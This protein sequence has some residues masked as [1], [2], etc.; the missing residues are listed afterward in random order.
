[1]QNN[2]TPW[3]GFL[4]DPD[5]TARINLLP[6][7][8]VHYLPGG[9]VP[10]FEQDPAAGAGRKYEWNGGTRYV[11]EPDPEPAGRNTRTVLILAAVG[12]LLAFVLAGVLVQ[13]ANLL[14]ASVPLIGMDS[15]VAT[16]QAIAA[17][18][19][20]VAGSPGGQPMTE[21]SYRELRA[22][23][24]DSRYPA[25]RDN[26]VQIVDISWQ[27]QALSEDEMFGALAYVG[28]ITSAY[29][30]LSGGCAE[31]GYTIPSLGD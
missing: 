12:A 8:P 29:A 23:F 5:Q 22:V 18:S 21:S 19:S 17:G 15:G 27:V 28:S 30:G 20:P 25:I 1:M 7:A 26:G 14:P 9:L 11:S 16:C 13:R 24:A 6:T 10:S 3:R 31:H 4:P 2:G